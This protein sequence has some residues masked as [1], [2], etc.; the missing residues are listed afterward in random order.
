MTQD[1]SQYPTVE[2]RDYIRPMIERGMPEAEVIGQ[3]TNGGVSPDLAHEIYAES[4]LKFDE[5]AV[6]QKAEQ[7]RKNLFDLMLGPLIMLLGLGLLLFFGNRHFY[8][9]WIYVLMIVFGLFK[10]VGGIVGMLSR[11]Q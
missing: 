2:L 8:G 10:C 1:L 6:L 11:K 4:R 7:S 9:T 3:L 5:Q